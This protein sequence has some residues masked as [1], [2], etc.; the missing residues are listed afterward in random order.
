VPHATPRI[1]NRVVPGEH[2]DARGGHTT[3]TDTHQHTDHSGLAGLAVYCPTCA[4]LIV[5]IANHTISHAERAALA[6][7]HSNC[8]EL[9]IYTPLHQSTS[10]NPSPTFHGA[11]RTIAYHHYPTPIAMPHHIIRTVFIHYT[12]PVH[13]T[14]QYTRA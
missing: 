7:D 6:I 4:E 9:S 13:N 1:G 3:H 8:G 12:F 2:H 11:V 10:T 14:V 5:V